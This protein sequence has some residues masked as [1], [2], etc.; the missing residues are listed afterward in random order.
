MV[1]APLAQL[2]FTTVQVCM[3]LKKL[4]NIAIIFQEVGIFRFVSVIATR[5]RHGKFVLGNTCTSFWLCVHRRSDGNAT[6][7]SYSAHKPIA[8]S[9]FWRP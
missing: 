5:G 7:S 8:D 6:L 9:H 1:L 3:V 4:K 2:V